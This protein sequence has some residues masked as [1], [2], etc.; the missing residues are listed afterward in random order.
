MALFFQS[1]KPQLNFRNDWLFY[2]RRHSLIPTPL[3]KGEGSTPFSLWEK[4][5]G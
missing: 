2:Q 4:G 3:P 5:W 1:K